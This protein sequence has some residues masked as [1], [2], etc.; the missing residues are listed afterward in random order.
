MAN[1]KLNGDRYR[2][3]SIDTAPGAAGEWCDAVG[4]AQVSAKALF[5]SYRG[6]GSATV[7]L[8][9][10]TPETGSAWTDYSTDE[11]IE[12]GSRYILDDHGAGVKWRAGVKQGGLASGTVIVGFDW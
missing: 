11:T 6:G 3:I 5:F 7:T 12:N 4:M 8:Q 1:T 10:R 9:F 2:Y